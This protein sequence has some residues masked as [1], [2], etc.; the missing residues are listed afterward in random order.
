MRI[1]IFLLIIHLIG[2]VIV[3]AGVKL[4]LLHLSKIIL[5]F[6][7]LVPFFGSVCAVIVGIFFSTTTNRRKKVD[8]EEALEDTSAQNS[9]V[10]E[11]E[12]NYQNIVSMEEALLINDPE[13]RRKLLLT[14]LNDD[15][16][17]YIEML[18][19]ARMNNDVEVVHY[20]TTALASISSDFD[21]QLQDF[22]RRYRKAP[23]NLELLQAYKNFLQQYLKSDFI[24]KHTYEIQRSQYVN[25]LQKLIDVGQGDLETYLEMIDTLLESKNYSRAL[26]YLGEV[27]KS[28]GDSQEYW[29]EKIKYYFSQHDHQQIIKTVKEIE[30]KNIY[31]SKQNRELVEYWMAKEERKKFHE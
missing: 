26:F 30:T 13:V 23:D 12:R 29:L 6:V 18:S 2:C 11:R 8:L 10:V 14:V 16:K 3:Y 15:P 4:R 24:E 9:L 27:E 22:E 1:I 21:I 17:Q 28:W 19:K 25:L 7:L 31:F 5:P 20:A